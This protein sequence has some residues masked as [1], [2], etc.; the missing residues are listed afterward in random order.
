MIR[1]EYLANIALAGRVTRYPVRAVPIGRRSL[2]D[3]VRKALG[4]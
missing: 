1:S 4:F 2:W 3:R